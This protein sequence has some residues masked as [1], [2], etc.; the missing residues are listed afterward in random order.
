MVLPANP[1]DLYLGVFNKYGQ[2]LLTE[3]EQKTQSL[4]WQLQDAAQ[5][6]S[7]YNYEGANWS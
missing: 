4:P 7:P 3:E 2:N 5:E 1:K 6:Y